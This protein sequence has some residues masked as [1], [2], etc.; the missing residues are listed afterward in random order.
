ME[1]T[2]SLP[3]APPSVLASMSPPC[4][5]PPLCSPPSVSKYV[6]G[7]CAMEKKTRSKPMREILRRLEKK[8]QFD[9]LV[10]D[11][12][13]II[14]R[15]VEAWPACDA[16]ISFYSTGF[17]LEK[18]EDYVRRVRPVLVNELGM[19][20]VLFDRRKVYALLTRHGIQVPRH[21][22]V[23][24]DLPGGKQDELI[25][26]DNYVEIN[27]VRINKP[28]VEKPADAEDHNVYIYYP[29]SAGG[30]SKRL[31][32]KVGDRSSEFYP[33]VNHVRRDGSYIY[34]EFL[35]TQGTDVKVYTVG[36]SYGHAEAR[37]SPVLDGRVVRDS[38]GKEVR[39]PVILNSTEKDMARKVCL[40]FHQTVCGFD[41]L[42]VRGSSYVCDVNGWS[43][44]KNSK[45]YY[46]DCGLILHNYLVSAL[47]SRYFRQ[48]RAN[49][50]T[51]MGTQMCPQYAT[52][53]S[54]GGHD[55]HNHTRP[56]S[57]SDVSESSVA[58]ASSAGFTL[59][60][61]NREELRC[62]IAVVRHGDRTPK[63]K[64]KT[65]VWERDLVNFYEK[66]RSERKYDEVKVKAV[67]DLQE[68]LD[69]VRSLIKAYAPGV[70]SKDAVWEDE[71]GDSFEKLLQM[72]RVLERW[73]FAGIN[74][75][76]QFKPHKSYAAA[77]AAYAEAPDGTEKPKVLMILKWGGDL[78]ERGK[79]QGE[80][81]GQSFRNSLYPVEVEEG[82]R[83][84]MTAAAFAKGFLEL[85][86]DLTPI[87]VSLVTTLG[88]DANKMLDHSGQADA[89]EEMQTIK[90]KLRTLLQRDYSS[91]EEMKAAIA[92]LKTESIIQAL[93]IIKTPKEALVRLL[94]LVR[95]FRTEIAERVQDKQADEATPLYMGETFSL[96]FERWDKIYRD[97]YSTKTDTFNLSKIPDVH[98]CIKY[99]LLHNSSVGWKY[100]LEL[101]KLAEAL[102]RCYVSQ[103]Y[104]MDTAE[105]QSIGNRV[106]QALCAKIRADIVTVM[107]AS[108]EQ[109][110]S[111]SSSRSLYGNG[112]VVEDGAV[113]IAEQDIEHHGYRLDPSYAKELR[114]KSPG[115]QVRTRL[116]FTSES[117]LHTL[118]NVLRF[119]CPSWRARHEG[120]EDD[121]YDISLEQ[122][123]FSNEILKRMGISV[124]DHMTQRKYVFR[125]SKLISDSSRR[126][127]DRVA[128]I[129]Y[130]AHVVIR[131]FETPSLPQDSEDRFRVEISFSPGV[132]DG[133]ADFPDGA[134]GV[135]DTIY[136]TKNMTGVMFEDMLAACVS[137]VQSTSV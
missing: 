96:M 84:Q 44:V 26:H 70:G 4:S 55:W 82:G 63:Q 53:P 131:V 75:K 66:R 132:K 79:Q 32:R 87:L 23:N 2:Q 90:T 49:S 39:Y 121:E 125:E 62:V 104:G 130:L 22:I 88:R 81:L 16:L 13:T 48:R 128:E 93:E 58:S 9:V 105:K 1:R 86:G 110:E 14:N 83:V 124:N 76:V 5:P 20:H 80:E 122:E 91:I 29:T 24:R 38:A 100:G 42:R 102:A 45:K 59:D 37:K 117:H 34:E 135:E 18:A 71:G 21:V 36:S 30:G 129:N 134:E 99:D 46:D 111:S 11:D 33:D 57:G 35:N 78:T 72:K 27:G 64:L 95:K 133:L 6:V 120:G 108:A 118:L 73:K 51:S 19:Q 17:P 41:L 54:V 106:S 50:L 8:R 136:L 114:I 67:A 3:V 116:Y 89:N 61:E 115:T 25:E 94:E 109:E 40:A 119:Q 97:F 68:L 126:A 60:D 52:E 74:R 69:L 107:S 123:K 47:R 65:L 85:D 77:A 98:D 127:L 28:F 31:F 113:D 15:P 101:F 112:D 10:F 43:F 56:S 7:V 12:E 103:E 92:P 137:S